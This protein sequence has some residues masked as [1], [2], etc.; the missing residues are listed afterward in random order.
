MGMMMSCFVFLFFY[1]SY[2]LFRVAKNFYFL[3]LSNLMVNLGEGKLI[4]FTRM[5]SFN[6]RVLLLWS[7]K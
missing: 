5:I 2:Q 3:F 4:I 6:V 7:G 1:F